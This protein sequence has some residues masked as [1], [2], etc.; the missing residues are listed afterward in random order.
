MHP[1]FQS[2]L[3]VCHTPEL[4]EYLNLFDNLRFGSPPDLGRGDRV[5][6]VFKRLTCFTDNHWLIKQLDEEI[7]G[8]VLE[9]A[10]DVETGGSQ[11][12][13]PWYA[14][15]S[16]VE[17][18]MIHIARAFVVSPHVIVLHKPFDDLEDHWALRILGMV[19]DLVRDDRGDL[20]KRTAFI[21]VGTRH[22][23]DLISKRA[24]LELVVDHD[25]VEV[26][27]MK[28]M[29]QVRAEQESGQQA[30]EANE[31]N[32][33]MPFF[34]ITTTLSEKQEKLLPE[35]VAQKTCADVS[36]RKQKR[37]KSRDKSR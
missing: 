9:T 4:M 37:K 7:F 16:S 20:R 18:K 25:R 6:E 3:Q 8:E 5:R 33:C 14:R 32:S 19:E 31:A 13:K 17:K 29:Q 26:G 11:G 24:N 22:M 21:S 10:E 30:N 28:T 12:K 36:D 2:V 1:P 35:K 23:R 34:N 15:L 27:R